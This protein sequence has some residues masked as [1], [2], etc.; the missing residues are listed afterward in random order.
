MA[1]I[2]GIEMDESAPSFTYYLLLLY[3]QMVFSLFNAAAVRGHTSQCVA[4]LRHSSGFI[5]W[6]H[7]TNISGLKR[8]LN[9]ISE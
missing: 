4:A 1:S 3:I 6:T 8:N 5:A 9:V 7:L 2:A